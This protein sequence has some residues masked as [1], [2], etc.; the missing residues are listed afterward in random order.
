MLNKLYDLFNTVSVTAWI[1]V[2]YIIKEKWTFDPRIHPLIVAVILIV[3]TVGAGGL[4]LFLTKFLGQDNLE[5]CLEIEQAD[6]SF[7]RPYIG[8]FLIAFNVHNIYQL[9]VATICISV[10][11]FLVRWQYFN[12]T[13]LFFGYHCYHVVTDTHTKIFIICRR[14]IRT[15]ENLRFQNLRRIN[16]TTYIE[17]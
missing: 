5:K 6:V 11:L 2:I 3:L 10:F 15:P 16:N 1:I 14:E 4:S 7:L 9:L 17:R 8:Y 13:Y 12:V